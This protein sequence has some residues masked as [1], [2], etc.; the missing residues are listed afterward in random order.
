VASSP[1]SHGADRDFLPFPPTTFNL[2]APGWD[3]HRAVR[4]VPDRRMRELGTDGQTASGCAEQ[5][6]DVVAAAAFSLAPQAGFCGG[7]RLRA[8]S[9][10]SWSQISRT[11]CAGSWHGLAALPTTLPSR[12]CRARPCTGRGWCLV[13]EITGR[14]SPI[15]EKFAAG[16]VRLPHL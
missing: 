4:L 11:Q 15:L 12:G 6:R 1:L 13:L 5:P 10:M 14:K 8:G 3:S 2:L 7:E 9:K 16:S